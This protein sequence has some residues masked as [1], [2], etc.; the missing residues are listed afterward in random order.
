MKLK[1]LGLTLCLLLSSCAIFRKVNK[2]TEEVKT[3]TKIEIKDTIAIKKIDTTSIIDTTD[4]YEIDIDIADVTKPVTINGV[5]YTNIKRFKAIKTKKGITY[6][7]KLDSTLN[8]LKITKSESKID[9]VKSSKQI[10][11]KSFDFTLLI[12]IVLVFLYIRYRFF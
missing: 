12:I 4:I 5:K 10:D 2:T 1:I 11:K 8:R 6:Q 7:S 3:E 9:V